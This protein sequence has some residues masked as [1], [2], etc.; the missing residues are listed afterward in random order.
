MIPTSGDADGIS[1][2]AAAVLGLLRHSSGMPAA[3]ICSRMSAL[4]R[5]R[6]VSPSSCWIAFICSRRKYSRC[7]LSIS[8]CT[9]HWILLLQLQHVELFRQGMLSFSSR[10]R[11]SSG[12]AGPRPRSSSRFRYARRSPPATRLARRSSPSRT[13]RQAAPRSC[14]TFS[15]S[16]STARRSASV[17]PPAP[18]TSSTGSPARC[19]AS[20]SWSTEHPQPAQALHPTWVVPSGSRSARV[21]RLGREA[22]AVVNGDV[23]QRRVALGDDGDHAVPF[24]ASHGAQGQAVPPDLGRCQQYWGRECRAAGRQKRQLER[25]IGAAAVE[26]GHVPVRVP[27]DACRPGVPFGVCPPVP[28]AAATRPLPRCPPPGPGPARTRPT[29][30]PGNSQPQY[31]APYRRMGRGELSWAPTIFG[32]DYGYSITRSIILTPHP[33]LLSDPVRRRTIASP[34][35]TPGTTCMTPS[36]ASGDSHGDGVAAGHVHSGPRLTARRHHY[37]RRRRHQWRSGHSGGARRPANIT[38]DAAATLHRGV[39]DPLYGR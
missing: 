28:A 7:D 20:R 18:A 33:P 38:F 3:A 12:S 4:A 8:S 32:F 34:F 1:P 27:R 2:C 9:R 17:A 21:R 24:V 39:P 22:K 31:R 35:R 14:T 19:S 10:S 16:A 30:R 36:R 13:R 37:L 25:G 6:V 11:G 15:N 29:P 26:R 23:G 5:L